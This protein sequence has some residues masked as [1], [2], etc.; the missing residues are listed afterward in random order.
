MDFD[1]MIVGMIAAAF[2]TFAVTLF[3]VSL[4]IKGA[5]DSQARG[6]KEHA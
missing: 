2:V 3:G 4:W 6:P 5:E 1:T